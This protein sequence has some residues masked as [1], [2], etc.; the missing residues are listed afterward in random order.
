MALSGAV[1]VYR[2]KTSNLSALSQESL[3]KLKPEVI[4][5]VEPGLEHVSYPK[6]VVPTKGSLPMSGFSK[7]Q[8]FDLQADYVVIPGPRFLQIVVNFASLFHPTTIGAYEAC[9]P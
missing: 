2:G 3:A 9:L 6:L 8:V 1:N 7:V 4:V 5:K